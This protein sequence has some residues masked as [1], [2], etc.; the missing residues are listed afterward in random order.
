MKKNLGHTFL[1]IPQNPTFK[2]KPGPSLVIT[3]GNLNI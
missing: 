2:K 1:K 3:Y